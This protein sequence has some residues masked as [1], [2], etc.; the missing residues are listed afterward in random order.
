MIDRR[1][2]LGVLATP[3]WLSRCGRPTYTY[4]YKLTL[5]VEVNGE[6]KQGFNV[7]EIT[8][9]VVPNGNPSLRGG[10]TGQSLFI[11]LGTGRPP[12][13][14]LLTTH[15]GSGIFRYTG[16]SQLSK[17]YGIQYEWFGDRNDGLA[18]LI[19]KRGAKPITIA[20]LPELVTFAD[21]ADPK[22]VLSVDP[23]NLEAT[24]GPGV[25]WRSMTLEFT[26]EA[27]TSGLE[28]KLP[29]LKDPKMRR[30]MLDGDRL[31]RFGSSATFTNSLSMADFTAQG[32]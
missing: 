28:K 26:N 16:I 27:V 3:L 4:R 13:V 1:N 5:Q 8:E 25:K 24:L 12:L 31:R 19:K 11:G 21:P 14:T 32:Y 15:I 22:T 6:V 17:I 30:T 10:S 20:Q 2:I 9:Y 18:M 23:N 7:V 29:W